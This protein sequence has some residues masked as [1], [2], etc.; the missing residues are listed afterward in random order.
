VRVEGAAV[1]AQKAL[2][3][4]AWVVEAGGP[5]GLVGFPG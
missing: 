4:G 2:P 1:I 5:S 3:G